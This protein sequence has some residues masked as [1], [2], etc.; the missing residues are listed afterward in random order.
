VQKDINE[1]KVKPGQYFILKFDFS[2]VRPNPD[3]TEA[4]ETLI[5]FL[6]SSLKTFYRTYA[7]YL[8]RD[9]TDLYQTI[10]SKEPNISLRR[11]A[12][13]VRHA[14]R[15]GGQFT[16]IEGIYVIVDEYDAFS[17]HYL[18]LQQTAGEP[19]IAWEGTAVA[20]TF[21]SFWSTVK[22]MGRDGFIRRVFITGI[23]PLS[24]SDLGSSFNVLTNLS[25]DSDLAGLCGLTRSDVEDVLKKICKDSV[26]RDLALWEMIEWYNGFHFCNYE[27]V[28]TVF[29]TETCL[30][31]LQ[32]LFR[33]KTTD[34]ENP[35]NSEISEE[36]LRAFTSSAPAIRDFERA[37]KLDETGEFESL[38]YG[39]FK[40]RLTLRDLVC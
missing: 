32:R 39:K 30:A 29:N 17:N 40:T 15:Q 37:M 13:S 2:K 26:K 5:K 21:K 3:L 27:K 31:H 8:G 38:E 12:Q 6:N 1:G 7:V 11:C 23:L 20:S 33:G 10:D 4:N 36:F 19:K 14:I 22:S 28:T 25:F 18:E 24:L 35:E 16:S 9:V 34:V